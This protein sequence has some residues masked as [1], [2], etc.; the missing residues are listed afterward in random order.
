M[1]DNAIQTTEITNAFSPD[2]F[3]HAQRVAKA[4][5][6]SDLVPKEF[7]G[8]V[9]NTL[10]ALEIAN[11]IGASPLFVMQNLYLVHGKPSWSSTF[12][13]SVI[14]QNEKFEGLEYELTGEGESL[15][16]FCWSYRKGTKDKVV[17][18]TVTMKMAKAEG[19]LDKNGSKWKTMPELMIRYRAA[20]FFGRLYAP[21]VLMGF[22]TSDEIQDIGHTVINGNGVAVEE[23]Q[24]LLDQKEGLLNKSEFDNA[25]RIID[26]KEV[27]SYRKLLTMLTEK[28]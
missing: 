8:N 3:E 6:S 16:C 15:S 23:L 2:T 21:E 4:L 25:R 17:G 11:R 19:W 14:N 20:T 28:V 27:Q 26:G 12:I 9:A 13:I 5:A 24:L 7:K 10:I 18:P 22:H 1:S